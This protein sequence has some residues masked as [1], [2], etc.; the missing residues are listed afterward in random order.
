MLTSWWKCCRTG[1]T[2]TFPGG[3]SVLA[4][5]LVT[6]GD[7]AGRQRLCGHSSARAKSARRQQLRQLGS[8]GAQDGASSSKTCM[9]IG[10][11]GWRLSIQALAITPLDG[12]GDPRLCRRRYRHRHRGRRHLAAGRIQRRLLS[13][14][15]SLTAVT[16]VYAPD[17]HAGRCLHRGGSAAGRAGRRPSRAVRAC[18]PAVW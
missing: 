14:T 2:Q 6:P 10:F 7:H 5:G 4:G 1:W 16:G 18:W 12:L 15:T 13:T 11:N 3:A 9:P 17:A 8:T